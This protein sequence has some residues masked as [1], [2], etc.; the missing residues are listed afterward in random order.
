M[1]KT[2][3]EAE[4]ALRG[5]TKAVGMVGLPNLTWA[6]SSDSERRVAV[7]LLTMAAVSSGERPRAVSKEPGKQTARVLAL[8]DEMVQAQRATR[9]AALLIAATIDL[10]VG[11]QQ[12]EPWLAKLIAVCG[13]CGA[14][15]DCSADPD[16]P[17]QAVARTVGTVTAQW[18]KAYSVPPA[19]TAE[20]LS[21]WQARVVY[22]VL[23]HN[24]LRL[25]K[26]QAAFVEGAILHGYEVPRM[27]LF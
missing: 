5:F 11:G 15:K 3:V 24:A 19:Q 12:R 8:D 1:A 25:E 22:G 16:S 4:T 6:L 21:I 27:Q 7:W 10:R 9:A 13:L 23:S 26:S 17:E 18:Q 20:D 2:L 14:L